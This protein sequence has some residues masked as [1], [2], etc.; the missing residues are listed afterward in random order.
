MLSLP[1]LL[2]SKMNKNKKQHCESSLKDLNSLR[3]E[4]QV[5]EI[6]S[7]S[8]LCTKP[9]IRTEACSQARGS[10]PL[11]QYMTF[12]WVIFTNNSWLSFT[13]SAHRSIY[14]ELHASVYTIQTNWL[15]VRAL[16][17]ALYCASLSIG[18]CCTCN[19]KKKKEK[20]HLQKP[21]HN[22]TEEVNREINTLI[23]PLGT[24]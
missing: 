11:F 23:L 15:R 1:W 18:A 4:R 14:C 3:C 13:C 24:R 12:I 16:L 5:F 6:T 19:S 17:H 10:L 8:A 9:E 2:N 22:S 20:K 21:S 7:P